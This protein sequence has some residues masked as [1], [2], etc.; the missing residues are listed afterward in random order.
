MKLYVTA[1]PAQP[2]EAMLF[3]E[4]ALIEQRYTFLCDLKGLVEEYK[5]N[6]SLTEVHL[7]GAPENYIGEIQD[8]LQE[9]FKGLEVICDKVAY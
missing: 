4:S 1:F 7:I 5:E 9:A 6:A 3:D 2:I 8:E